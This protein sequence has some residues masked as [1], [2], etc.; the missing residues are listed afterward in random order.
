MN[1]I[2]LALALI[3]ASFLI[4]CASPTPAPAFD[5]TKYIIVKPTPELLKTCVTTPPPAVDD[6]MAMN[7]EQREKILSE[8]SV[9]LL[10]DLNA[11]NQR[12]LAFP[13]WFEDQSNAYMK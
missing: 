2:K 13:K 5:T 6:Y 9:A 10:N 12:W 7:K 3:I 4:A 1:Y 8:Y 11:C